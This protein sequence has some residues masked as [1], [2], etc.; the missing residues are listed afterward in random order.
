MVQPLVAVVAAEPGL[1]WGLLPAVWHRLARRAVGL[2][3][4]PGSLDHRRAWV[5]P[6]LVI[7]PCDLDWPEEFSLGTKPTK[8]PIVD[9]LNRCQSPIS[10][11][12]PNPV[13]V[14][15]PRRHPSRRVTAV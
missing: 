1:G 2:G 8:D 4:M 9:P 3:V 15:I 13:R 10:T 6:V 12:S 7:E 5:L 14:E 11:A